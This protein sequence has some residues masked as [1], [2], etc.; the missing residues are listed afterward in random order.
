MFELP[1]PLEILE[2]LA[3]A[4]G[5]TQAVERLLALGAWERLPDPYDPSVSAAQA[6][7]LLAAGEDP[8]KDDEQSAMASVVVDD[9]FRAWGGPTGGPR[10]AYLLDMELG[11]LAL[12]A[13]DVEVLASVAEDALAGFE[14]TFQYRAGARFGREAVK[15]LDAAER[16]ISPLCLRN[17]ADLLVRTGDTP[18]ARKLFARAV[19]VIP[20][21]IPEDEAL[22]ATYSS[23]LL[24]HARLLVQDGELDAAETH[25]NE[26]LRF[27]TADSPRKRA[28]RL[29]EIARIKA[30]RGDVDAALEL[31]N[32]MLKCLREPGRPA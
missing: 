8:L 19:A 21:E 14:E 28:I 10:R 1:V 15:R 11:R 32:E 2:S 16:D 20:S 22:A 9:L 24:S 30:T 26:S 3:A 27:I 6:N 13:D 18:A 12:L 7:A 29:G 25:L 31:H 5:R 23:V 4:L 17:A